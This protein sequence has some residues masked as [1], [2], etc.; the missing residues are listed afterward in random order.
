MC[1]QHPQRLQVTA[2]LG[3]GAE[4]SATRPQRDH[5]NRH[6][7]ANGKTECGGVVDHGHYQHQEH[8][9]RN[10]LGKPEASVIVFEHRCRLPQHRLAVCRPQHHDQR[11]H[12]AYRCPKQAGD[13][14]ATG[15]DRSDHPEIV[16]RR[17]LCRAEAQQLMGESKVAERG[18]DRV[19]NQDQRNRRVGGH[20]QPSSEHESCDAECRLISHT[21]DRHPRP[22]CGNGAGGRRRFNRYRRH[23]APV[24]TRALALITLLHLRQT[25][26]ETA[27]RGNRSCR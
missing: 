15:V 24:G 21:S 10:N 25:A 22:A 8:R 26:T 23:L 1:D 5:L 2:S 16:Q 7:D 6:P 14:N 18:C 9:C 19:A 20:R 12:R 17:S 3:G 13:N 27:T 11:R 4:P